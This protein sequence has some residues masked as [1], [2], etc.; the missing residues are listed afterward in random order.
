M[1]TPSKIKRK[2]WITYDFTLAPGESKE[3]HSKI[4]NYAVRATRIGDTVTIYK[5]FGTGNFKTHTHMS[6]EA[7]KA[8]LSEPM[9][10]GS[11]VEAF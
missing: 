4:G 7:Y 9:N 1:L 11:L 3:H 6:Y 5:R 10:H 2:S 8:K